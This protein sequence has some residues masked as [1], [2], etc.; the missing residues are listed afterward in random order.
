[1]GAGSSTIIF[2]LI[3]AYVA[4]MFMN[5]NVLRE[6]R[7]IICNTIVSF[8]FLGIMFSYFDEFNYLGYIGG[9]VGGFLISLAAFPTILPKKKWMMG[10][11]V[12]GLGMYFLITFLVFFLS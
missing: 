8:L 3:G 9:I 2:G 7:T 1:M 4:Y 12:G 10:L 5:W 6:L 11:G